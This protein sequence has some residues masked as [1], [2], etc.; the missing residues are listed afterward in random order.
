MCLSVVGFVT[1]AVAIAIVLKGESD[2]RRVLQNIQFIED[3]LKSFDITDGSSRRGSE[4][5]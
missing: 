5:D 4:Q 1:L 2:K 3:L